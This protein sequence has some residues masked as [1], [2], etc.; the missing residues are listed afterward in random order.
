MASYGKNYTSNNSNNNGPLPY[1]TQPQQ[2]YGGY[3]QNY[4][5]QNSYSQQYNQQP[6][7]YRTNGN[8]YPQQSQSMGYGTSQNS[9]SMS[10]MSQLTSPYQPNNN[11]HNRP[12]YNQMQQQQQQQ[13]NM[14]STYN[15]QAE[16]RVR[17]LLMEHHKR[18]KLQGVPHEVSLDQLKREISSSP[19][20]IEALRNIRHRALQQKMSQ[21]RYY[22]Q[23]NSGYP[24]QYNNNNSH[25]P[26]SL[27][28]AMPENRYYPPGQFHGDY[29]SNNN[30]QQN[31]YMQQQ[32]H[33]QQQ[34]YNQQGYP[35]QNNPNNPN[36]MQQHSTITPKPPL[37]KHSLNA[38]MA[39]SLIQQTA[40][41]ATG[42]LPD[43]ALD[44]IKNPVDEETIEHENLEDLSE[45]DRKIETIMR[46]CE[47]ISKQ[48]RESL[49]THL[50]SLLSE[51]KEP[52]CL[53][54][55]F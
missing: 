46:K 27:R 6:Q 22:Q 21:Q 55:L 47:S 33:Q 2:G 32:Q 38:E 1:Q 20:L 41:G 11:M 16:W 37:I 43:N 31:Q 19:E 51:E 49:Q 15:S 34:Q 52:V 17:T 45:G 30:Y 4:Q 44:A 26:D 24:M 28:A 12:A 35:M 5:S 36:F 48:L 53:F 18:S 10:F 42:T 7:S 3:P 50:K 39:N 54:F 14:P 9:Q 23:N 25:I 29:Q 40:A 13:N 8:Q